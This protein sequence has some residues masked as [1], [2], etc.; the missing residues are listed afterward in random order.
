M[1]SLSILSNSSILFLL[2][3]LSKVSVILILNNLL[4][5]RNFNIYI[6]GKTNKIKEYLYKDSYKKVINIKKINN[7]LI[8]NTN[9]PLYKVFF[10][11]IF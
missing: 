9:N 1:S 6:I 3:I 2:V 7:K 5:L 11:N 10:N 8:L 4:S